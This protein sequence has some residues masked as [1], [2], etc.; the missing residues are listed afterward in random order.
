MK[1]GSKF[2][3]SN[4]LALG[5]LIISIILVLSIVISA[6]TPGTAPNPGH[7]I[8]DDVSPPTGCLANQ[9]LQWTGSTWTCVGDSYI[10]RRVSGTCIGKVMTGI[11]SDGSVSCEDD[12]TGTG[13][14]L[15]PIVYRRSSSDSENEMFTNPHLF[16]FLTETLT[17][18]NAGGGCYVRQASEGRWQYGKWGQF[19]SCAIRCVD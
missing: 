12:D 5:I 4:K 10:Q 2:D 14:T 13:L 11:N 9:V 17:T 16:C 19:T 6:L 18:Y 3:W 8:T 15:N 1:K 7:L